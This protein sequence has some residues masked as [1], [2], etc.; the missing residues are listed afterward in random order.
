MDPTV[1]GAGLERV[2][3]AESRCRTKASPRALPAASC[4]AADGG[5]GDIGDRG[6]APVTEFE[7]RRRAHFG[8]RGVSRSVNL[9]PVGRV[10]LTRPRTDSP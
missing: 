9:M 8:C 6:D 2:P 10:T 7:A 3:A 5:R 1:L 4:L